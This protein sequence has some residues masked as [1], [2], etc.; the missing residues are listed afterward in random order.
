MLEETTTAVRR[1]KRFILNQ[2]NASLA[3]QS[4]ADVGYPFGSLT[5]YDIDESGIF[6]IYVSYI[7]E[8]Y[9][10]LAANP[11][12]SLLICDP[13]AAHDP[14]AFGRA[15]VLLDLA[16]IMASEL[17]NSQERFEARFP[18]SIQ[19]EIAHNFL[20]LRGTAQRIRW[21]GG[22]GDIHWIDAV[23]FQEEQF[24]SVA[25][26]A[27]EIIEH[28]HIDHLDALVLLAN[29]YGKTLVAKHEVSMVAINAEALVLQVK[30]GNQFER[31]TIPFA[32]PATNMD[33]A[34]VRLIELLK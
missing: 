32:A 21:I 33:D 11:K 2:R 20:F 4:K 22:F 3:T 16:P 25:Y 10:N 17:A 26:H 15:T 1:V 13:Y 14:Q 24:D 34:R 19:Y 9:K 7:A 6:T 5:Q 31:I 23:K 12:A 27:H 8:H 29:R 18:G 30:R 28:M